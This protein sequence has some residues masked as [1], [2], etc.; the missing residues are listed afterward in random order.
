MTALVIVFALAI[1]AV[2]AH[3]CGHAH[4]KTVWRNDFGSNVTFIS[5]G[6]TLHGYYSPRNVANTGSVGHFPLVGWII[7]QNTSYSILSWTVS[8]E[9]ADGIT[10]WIGYISGELLYTNNTLIL[11][12][13]YTYMGP[14]NYRLLA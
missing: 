13:D 9:N 3:Q 8:W 1:L 7:P 12:E 6:G 5:T 11:P 2:A 14:D 4:C 10:T